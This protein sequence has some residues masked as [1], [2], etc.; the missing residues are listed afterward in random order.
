M[1]ARRAGDLPKRT[2]KILFINLSGFE[3]LT[4]FL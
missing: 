1:E 4:G 2:I 3:N